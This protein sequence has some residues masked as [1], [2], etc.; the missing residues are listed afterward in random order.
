MIERLQILLVFLAPLVL[1]VGLHLFGLTVP[2]P[3]VGRGYVVRIDLPPAGQP[4]DL[5]EILGPADASRPLVVIDAGHGG[6]DP[7]AS[8][9]A[10]KEK[11]LVLTLAR[12]LRDQLIEQGGVRVALTRSDDRLIVLRERFDIAQRL[13]ADLFISIH[14]D[15]S[16][17]TDATGAT[18]YTLDQEASDAE[19]ARFA[20]RENSADTING[21][22]ISGQPTA[23]DDIL[24]DL[25]QRRVQG[26]S[27]EFARLVYREG[28]GLMG[29]NPNP[30]RSADLAVLKSLD[31]PSILIESGFISNERDATRLVAPETRTRF[32]QSVARAIRIY[33]AQAS[34]Q[35]V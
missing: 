7:G 8:R 10:L 34:A 13:G 20:A 28:R 25:A 2:I 15:A 17:N 31:M 19:A 23:V 32:A 5:P 18:L 33:F 22:R 27:R 1:L 16:E 11:T 6:T 12:A 26:E 4:L 3:E 30:F 29:F 21:V 9:G 35:G 14:A 24:V